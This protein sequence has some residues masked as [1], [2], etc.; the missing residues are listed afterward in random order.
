M[1]IIRPSKSPY[2]SPAFQIIK[3]NGKIRSVIDYRKLNSITVPNPYIFPTIQDLLS[4]L[5]TS[6]IFSKIDLN[7]G[8]YQIPLEENLIKYTVFSIN[9]TKYEF[10]RMPFGLS[11]APITFQNAMDNIFENLN[12]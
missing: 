2:S 10:L 11:N 1:N 9:N 8:Y 6:K 3:R 12:L 4:Q 5:N 7:L